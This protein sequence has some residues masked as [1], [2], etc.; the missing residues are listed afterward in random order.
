MGT[1]VGLLLAGFILALH[2][3]GL[4]LAATLMVL[5][6]VIELCVVR[7]YALAVVFITAAA[8]TIASGGQSVADLGHLLLVRGLIR[9][10]A[11]RLGWRSSA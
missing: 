1:W 10:S 7:N 4:W 3:R 8:L 2:P 11:A 6:L 9:R 5:Q